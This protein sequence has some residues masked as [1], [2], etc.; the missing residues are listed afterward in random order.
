MSLFIDISNTLYCA[1]DL[2]HQVVKASLNNSSTTV[3][4]AAGN[5]TQ[6]SG[7]YMLYY[8]NGIFV[9][10]N[11]NLYVADCWNHRIQFFQT[12]QLNGSTIAGNGSSVTIVL[13]YPTDVVL[14]FDGYLF[15]TDCGNNRIVGSGP[16]GYYCIVGCTGSSGTASNQLH[17]PE[18]IAFDSYGNLFV[19]DQYNSRIQKFV[20]ATNSC[21]EIKSY[22][23]K[24]VI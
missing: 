7:P 4:L 14:D 20:L 1:N 24:D 2:Q 16:S 18:A 11:L 10:F 12:G 21:G 19:V 3:T 15:I 5:G 23:V 6:G 13:Y 9:D 17:N 22:I 8:P